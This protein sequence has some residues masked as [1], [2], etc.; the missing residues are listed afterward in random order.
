[1]NANSNTRQTSTKV[2]SCPLASFAVTEQEP[3]SRK[4]L[5]GTCLSCLVSD[6]SCFRDTGAYFWR[7]AL[8]RIPE[9]L[10]RC[11]RFTDVYCE[12]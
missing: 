5:D 2:Q 3:C 6:T 8:Y 11:F 1:M 4:P 9:R 7:S 12:L 10:S